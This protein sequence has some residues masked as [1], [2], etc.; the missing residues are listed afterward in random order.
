MDYPRLQFYRKERA[1]LL[2]STKSDNPT[3]PSKGILNS[4]ILYE[5][6]FQL[7]DYLYFKTWTPNSMFVEI[8]FSKDFAPVAGTDL[9]F[10]RLLQILPITKII[11]IF[12]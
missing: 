2:I 1:A 6:W 11:Y 10:K 12:R 7:K 4:H 9:K 3:I 8:C 5:I